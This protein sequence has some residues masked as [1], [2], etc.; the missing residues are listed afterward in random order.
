M[1]FAFFGS[2]KSMAGYR[3]DLALMQINTTRLVGSLKTRIQPL[4]AF[5]AAFGFCWCSW[6]ACSARLGSLK[7]QFWQFRLLIFVL[8][9][10]D[11]NANQAVFVFTG[12]TLGKLLGSLNQRSCAGQR[13]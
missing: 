12:H 11:A 7:T 5:Q 8:Q 9:M 6:L 1:V 4:S 3:D 10:A 2:L 13:G